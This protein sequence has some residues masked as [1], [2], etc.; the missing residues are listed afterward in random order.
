MVVHSPAAMRRC[1]E[2]LGY[3]ESEIGPPVEEEP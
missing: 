3:N 2:H 1:M